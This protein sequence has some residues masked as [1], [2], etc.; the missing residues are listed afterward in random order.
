MTQV[1]KTLTLVPDDDSD[2]L[3]VLPDSRDLYALRDMVEQRKWPEQMSADPIRQTYA[4]AFL[5]CRRLG[6]VDQATKFGDWWPKY[7]LILPEIEA[8]ALEV[9]PTNAVP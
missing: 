1:L 8:E 4:L 3:E 6:L 7:N 2:T 9:G 5:A